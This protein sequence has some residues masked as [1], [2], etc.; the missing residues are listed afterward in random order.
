MFDQIGFEV[1]FVR[2]VHQALFSDDK[3]AGVLKSLTIEELQQKIGYDLLL[4]A[5]IITPLFLISLHFLTAPIK[6]RYEHRFPAL[7]APIAIVT[8]FCFNEVSIA[9]LGV[10]VLL[11]NLYITWYLVDYDDTWEEDSRR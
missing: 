7:I 9:M 6:K 8:F 2:F 11:Q 4:L 10:L 5:F 3:N 1:H